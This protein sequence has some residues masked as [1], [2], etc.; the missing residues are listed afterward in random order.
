MKREFATVLAGIF[1]ERTCMNISECLTEFRISLAEFRMSLA[2][3]HNNLAVF[4]N[5]A[6]DIIE[7]KLI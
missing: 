3:F 4:P 6:A 5:Q 7:L 2:E 1:P